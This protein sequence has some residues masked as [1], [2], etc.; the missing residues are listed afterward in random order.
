MTASLRL[1]LLLV[2]PP[3]ALLLLMS[4]AIGAAQAV[5]APPP[6]ALLLPSLA[7]VGYV[8][9]SVALNDLADEKVDR[10]NLPRSPERPLVSGAGTR[11]RLT[12]VAA[13]GGGVA[14][15]AA[16]ASGWWSLLVVVLGL[17]LSAAYSLPPTRLSARGAVAS[18]VL[19]AAFVAV[20]FLL[21]LLAVGGAV[22]ARAGA[23]LAALY[24]GFVGR[25]LLKD[26]RDL[27]GDLLF[28][29]RTYLVRHGRLV[30]C[31][32]SAVLWLVSTVAL[33]AV[34]PE[35]TWWTIVALVGCALAAVAALRA[36][37]TDAGPHRDERLVAAAAIA[38]RGT[39]V[40][41]LGHLS[42]TTTGWPWWVQAAFVGA[43]LAVTLGQA[44]EMVTWGPRL[45]AWRTGLVDAATSASAR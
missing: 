10:V 41:V 39:M 25:I 11:E 31:R 33:V 17:A 35:R 23:L 3:V 5:G 14:L 19:P 21:G 8:L 42:L 43:L 12:V 29:K 44:R 38:G 32:T 28:G 36:L 22:D 34:L 4:L 37:E 15:L 16:A 20:P 13:V 6:A 2:R 45:V 30:T 9:W 27:R 26:F 18:L 1:T 40:V 7:V 24:L